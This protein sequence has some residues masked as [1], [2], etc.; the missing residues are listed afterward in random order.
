M[1]NFPTTDMCGSVPRIC[2]S[3]EVLSGSW[4]GVSVDRA[5]GHFPHSEPVPGGVFHLQLAGCQFAAVFLWCR[6]SEYPWDLAVSCIGAAISEVESRQGLNTCPKYSFASGAPWCKFECH[7]S[8][9]VLLTCDELSLRPA[10]WFMMAV[11]G[12]SQSRSS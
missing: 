11:Q 10:L 1:V 9:S 2:T 3:A 12:L 5:S 8:Q 4:W 7:L 6:P